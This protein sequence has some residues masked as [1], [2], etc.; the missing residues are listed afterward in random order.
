MGTYRFWLKEEEKA[1]ADPETHQ[2]FLKGFKLEWGKT[3]LGKIDMSYLAQRVDPMILM[4]A[5]K[6][7]QVRDRNHKYINRMHKSR[8]AYSYS[9]IS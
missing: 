1:S 8:D 6:D 9:N 2:K 5:Q 7:P 4:K 3:V